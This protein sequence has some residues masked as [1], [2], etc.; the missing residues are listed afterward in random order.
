VE[1]SGK[2]RLQ[3]EE[4]LVACA[5]KRVIDDM[6]VGVGTNALYS[7][8]DWIDPRFPSVVSPLLPPIV[9]LESPE[10]SWSLEE[11]ES[12]PRPPAEAQAGA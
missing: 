11:A 1:D 12:R 8:P 2:F 7:E 10:I 4:K 5:T 6:M 9:S 3:G